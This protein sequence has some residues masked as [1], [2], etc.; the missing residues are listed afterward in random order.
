M[1]EQL[2]IYPMFAVPMF[3][4][5]IDN[6][7]ENKKKILNAL[8]PK[9]KSP[10]FNKSNAMYS[11]YW[12]QTGPDATFE[13][14]TYGPVVIDIIEEQLA[15]FTKV[16]FEPDQVDGKGTWIGFTDMWYQTFTGGQEHDVHNHGYTGW[17][18]VIYV[19][20]DEDVHV[21]THFYGQGYKAHGGYV[22]HFE[23]PV[24]EGDLIIFPS[25]VPHRAFVNASDTQRT[26]I[27]FNMKSY[28]ENIREEIIFKFGEEAEKFEQE[29][30][31]KE[32]KI[33]KPLPKSL[34]LPN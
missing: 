1:A 13:L 31:K 20:H 12:T 18:G 7:S 27:S 32:D 29:K 28:Q 22:E 34:I 11:D 14:P 16:I 19:E 33:F 8:P 23:P 3:H 30:N 9:E 26:I 5:S 25:T 6:W 21:P 24:K 4:F 15:E 17:S 10:I 2:R